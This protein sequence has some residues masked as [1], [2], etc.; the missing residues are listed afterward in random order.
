MNYPA[1]KEEIFV[2]QWELRNAGEGRGL[3]ARL[4]QLSQLD[5]TRAVARWTGHRPKT[6]V[7]R[8]R[9]TGEDVAALTWMEG[10]AAALPVALE[11]ESLA[12]VA[13]GSLL[14][15]G[16][17][18]EAIGASPEDESLVHLDQLMS[19][20]IGQ[21]FNEGLLFALFGVPGKGR[22]AAVGDAAAPRRGL[23]G[24]HD[25]PV[26]GRALGRDRADPSPGDGPRPGAAAAAAVL[27]DAGLVEEA[28]RA[29]AAGPVGLLRR[30]P[31]RQRPAAHPRKGDQAP[32]RGAGPR[33]GSPSTSG[34]VVLGLGR[35]FSRDLVGNTPT[36]A[37]DLER[38]LTRQGY[39]AG[40]APAYGSPSLE[41]QLTT[42]RELGHNALLLAPFLDS[43]EP[44]LQVMA[45]C[46]KVKMKV[47][48]VLV[49]ATSASV[50]A[51]LQLS[52]VPHRT[53]LVVPHW[54]GVVR[55]SAVVPFVGGWSIKEPQGPAADSLS[56]S[57]NDCLPY[58]DPHPLGLDPDG[59]LDF[60]RLALEQAALL[61]QVLEEAFRVAEGRLLT[62]NDLSAVVRHPPLPAL[63]QGVHH[64]PG[65]GP[66]RD[67][68]P[69]SGGP[70]TSVAGRP[71]RPPGGLAARIAVC[72]REAGRFGPW[73]A[74]GMAWINFFDIL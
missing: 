70:G 68:Q 62:L 35:Q 15:A 42:A 17:L 39:E 38:Y 64:A 31:A 56:P 69:G 24:R 57:I 13:G 58:H 37:L 5:A 26:P 71:Q 54:R 53:G 23:A 61:F 60:S 32:A 43:A 51:A 33:S 52:G 9:E 12:E 18:V 67:H 45:A 34:W 14:G 41:L 72:Q 21:W 73:S 30:A 16:A 29:S 2:S 11:D 55:E 66:Q 1:R 4:E 65:P 19:R 10:T 47:R 7:L 59:A 8:F 49:G 63:S 46:R 44:V 74:C 25:Q 3:P 27:P 40:I 20:I 50:H 6:A 36:F 28:V 48:E 22:R